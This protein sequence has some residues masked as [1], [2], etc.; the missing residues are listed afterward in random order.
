MGPLAPCLRGTFKFT[1]PTAD[2]SPLAAG[3]YDVKR[4]EIGGAQLS[5][6]IQ[7]PQN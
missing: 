7:K 4:Q 6:I 3:S 1:S 2:W 5:T